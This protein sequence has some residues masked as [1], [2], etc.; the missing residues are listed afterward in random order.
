MFLLDGRVEKRAVFDDR[1]A[2]GGTGAIA[3]EAD[4]G[5]LS[6]KRIACVQRPVLQEKECVAVELV[7]ADPGDE[8]DGT[9]GGAAP[10]RPTV[11]S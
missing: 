9:A 2:E 1:T 4:R 3:L 11:L 5:V 7:R 10:P 6:F 8:V